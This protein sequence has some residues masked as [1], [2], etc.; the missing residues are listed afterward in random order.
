MLCKDKNTMFAQ[1]IADAVLAV[2]RQLTVPEQMFSIEDNKP[3]GIPAVKAL[4]IASQQG[5]KIWTIDKNNLSLALS[6]INLGADAELDIRNAVNAGKIAT[7]H[8]TRINFNG[9]IGEGYTLVD[10]NTGAG[11]YMISGGGN[12]GTLIALGFSLIMLT[13]FLGSLVAVGAP[14]SALLFPSLI[15]L[16]SVLVAAGSLLIAAGF[17]LLEGDALSCKR[18]LAM[19]QAAL[20]G[21]LSFLIPIVGTLVVGI[22]MA[23]IYADSDKVCEAK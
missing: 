19:A 20:I 3:Q 13:I 1:F 22:F 14:V 6:R 23:G 10:P 4:A 5:Q 16:G 2:C 11:A 15:T 12:G 9:W 8:E 18:F 21:A 17:A 7:A